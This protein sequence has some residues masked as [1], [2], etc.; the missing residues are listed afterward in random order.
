[1]ARLTAKEASEIADKHDAA[2]V[3]RMADPII[4]R[5]LAEV[6]AFAE[7]GQRQIPLDLEPCYAF[8]NQKTADRLIRSVKETLAALGY[9][10]T[11]DPAEW[12]ANTHTG[13]GG[14]VDR[15]QFISWK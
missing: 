13:R 10:I 2:E 11:T 9:T 3:T 4:D 7:S 12:R 8:D 14:C 6:K 5:I 1:M 15:V